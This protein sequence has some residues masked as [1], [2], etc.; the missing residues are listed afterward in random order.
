MARPRL[1]RSGWGQY[2]RTV[3][4]ADVVAIL[5][6][7]GLAAFAQAVTGFGF[8]LLIVPPL[9]LVIGP[10]ETVVVANIL[11]TATNVAMLSRVHGHVDWRLGGWL[12]GGALVGMPVGLAVLIWINAAVLQV[13]IA[14]TV[15]ASGLLLLRGLRFHAAGR[16]WDA[17]TGVISGVLNTSTSMSGPPVVLYLQGREVSPDRF[18]ATLTAYFLA[19]SVVAVGLLAMAGKFTRD[20]GLEAAVGVPAVGVGIA[21]GLLV[22]RRVDAVLFRRLVFALLFASAGIAG[23]AALVR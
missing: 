23:L 10:K 7:A 6:L 17:V 1:A 14:I 20:V 15:L 4:P 12:F 8:S 2:N 16:A 19:S 22:Y 18:R 5:L 11:S 21:A 13:L 3:S 9:A